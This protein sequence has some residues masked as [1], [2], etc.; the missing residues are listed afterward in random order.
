MRHIA[1]TMLALLI[2]TGLLA[3]P[4]LAHVRTANTKVKFTASDTK[5][6]SGQKVILTAKIKSPW[7]KCLKKRKVALYRKGVKLTQKKATYQP[8]KNRAIAKFRINPTR[9]AKWW[10]KVKPRKWGKHP[11]RHVCKGRESKHIQIKVV[12]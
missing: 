4:A 12:H 3:E 11:H 5:V 8:N 10:V 2:A 7:D 1:R 9:T 6:Q